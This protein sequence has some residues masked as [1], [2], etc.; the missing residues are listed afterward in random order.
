MSGTELGDDELVYRRIPPGSQWLEP[1]DRISSFNFKLRK[2]ENGVSVFRASVLTPQQVLTLPEAIPDSMIAMARVGD[3][4]ELKD[5]KG[6]DLKLVVV[7]DDD[8][9]NPGHSEIRGP[10]PGE[11]ASAA[12]N[13][14]RKLFKLVPLDPAN[15]GSDEASP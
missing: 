13:A 3:I 10:M 4:R 14:L 11:M 15:P 5:G 1:P 6:K 8:E 9:N 2:D 7:A 12:S